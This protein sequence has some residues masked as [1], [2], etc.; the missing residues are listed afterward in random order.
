M[1]PSPY[2]SSDPDPSSTCASEDDDGARVVGDDPIGYGATGM[3]DSD[4]ADGLYVNPP[5][6]GWSNLH[7]GPNLQMP[8]RV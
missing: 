6:N 4:D 7:V 8:Y 2:A 5:T 3:S 1:L